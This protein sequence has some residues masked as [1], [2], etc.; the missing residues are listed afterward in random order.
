MG[1]PLPNSIGLTKYLAF[2][3]PQIP[4]AILLWI[5]GTSDRYFI[6]HFL[7]LSK[8]GIYTSSDTLRRIAWIILRPDS[9]RALPNVSQ[10]IGRKTAHHD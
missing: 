3:V 9:I 4:G 5:I 2:S 7:G 1:W 6:T 8:T 10:V